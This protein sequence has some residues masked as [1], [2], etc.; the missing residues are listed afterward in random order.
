MTYMT[1]GQEDVTVKISLSMYHKEM[2][3]EGLLVEKLCC[4]AVDALLEG[5]CSGC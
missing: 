4:R 5:V 1:Q 3:E 2:E